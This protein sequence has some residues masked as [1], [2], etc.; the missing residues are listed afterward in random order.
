MSL[1][2]P[3]V[4]AFDGIAHRRIVSRLRRARTGP[5]STAGPDRVRRA[6]AEWAIRARDDSPDESDVI[7]H[8]ARLKRKHL[9]VRQLFQAAPTCSAR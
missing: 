9:P 8:Q 6:V 5:T 4:G 2:D 1:T 3:I 7:E